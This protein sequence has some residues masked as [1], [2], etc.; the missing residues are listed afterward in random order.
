M[1]SYNFPPF[2]RFPL[3][4]DTTIIS[5]MSNN[6]NTSYKFYQIILNRKS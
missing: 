3:Q 1:K 4:K 5:T 2:Q 6:Y